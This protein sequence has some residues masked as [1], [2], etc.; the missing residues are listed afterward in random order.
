M[1]SLSQ[2]PG[3]QRLVLLDRQRHRARGIRADAGRF[4]ATLQSVYLTLPEFTAAAR[5]F[6]IVFARE[7][8]GTLHPFAVLSP[9]PGANA[10][11]DAHGAWRESAYCPAYVR[12]YPFA[13]TLTEEA[14]TPKAVVCVDEAGLDDSVPHLF[15]AR[16]EPTPHWRERQRFLEEFDAAQ[17]HT[18]AF[19]ARLEQLG[20][21]ESFVAEFSP[22]NG[23]PA[24][25]V[26]LWRVQEEKLRQLPDPT[27]GA[28]VRDGTLGRIFLH[29]NSLDNFQQLPDPR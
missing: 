21:V 22:V 2:P 14:G 5:H 12:R 13:T 18:R 19:C 3:Y 1:T 4:A 25:L 17:A 10:W 26:D 8:H 7:P 24:R 15:D 28:L 6:P 20:I 11:V 29:L 23:P 9:V 27:L 16:G